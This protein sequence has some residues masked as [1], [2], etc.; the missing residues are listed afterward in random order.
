MVILAVW[1]CY[2]GTATSIIIS[3]ASRTRSGLRFGSSRSAIG[4]LARSTSSRSP[5]TIDD[6][7]VA[8]WCPTKPIQAQD[9]IDLCYRLH[10]LADE[11][12]PTPLGRCVAT[13]LGPGGRP[14]LPRGRQE[15]Q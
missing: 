7:I 8:Y 9:R 2:S 4:I 13:R 15:A 14:A 10:C 3:M 12:Y 5:P 1:A 6:N 11:P